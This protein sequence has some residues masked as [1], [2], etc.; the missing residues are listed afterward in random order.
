MDDI[1]QILNSLSLNPDGIARQ[2]MSLSSLFN[3]VLAGAMGFLVLLVYFI[4][5]GKENRDKN[6]FMV[7]PVLSILMAVMMRIE[8]PQIVVFFGIFGILSVVRFRSDITDQKGITF[9]LFALIEG[10]LVGV[11]GYLL[12]LLGWMVVGG[13]I[14]LA[15]R[16]FI[17]RLS[18]RLVLRSAQ[19][20]PELRETVETWLKAQGLGYHFVSDTSATELSKAGVWEQKY[21]MD[22]LLLPGSEAELRSRTPALVDQTLAWGLELDLKKAD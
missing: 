17:G 11:N 5:S 13:A 3:I 14:L 22:F 16:I 20:R 15:R 19:I 6:L 18:F 7:I 10:V 21:R 8:S 4:A 9:I 2:F 1:D 12:A